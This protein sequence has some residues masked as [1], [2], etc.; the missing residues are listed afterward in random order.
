MHF[1]M[2]PVKTYIRRKLNERGYYWIRGLGEELCTIED[3]RQRANGIKQRFRQ[4]DEATVAALRKKY[5]QPIIGEVSVCRL[6]ELLAQVIDPANNYLYCGSQLT[7]TLQVAESME[8]AGINETTN[9]EMIVFGLIH[10]LGE[11]ALLKG[12]LPEHVEGGGK[13]PLRKYP[14]GIGLGNCAFTWDHSDIVHA[15]FRP[16]VSENIAWL[17]R[18]HSITP[19]CVLLMDERDRELYK[20]YHQTFIPHDRTYVFYHL[21]AKQLEDYRGLLEEAFPEKILF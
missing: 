13:R 20:S 18:Y 16:Y 5:E 3:F 12:E 8:R 7:H 17:L 2:R 9:R 21:P 10:D 14:A 1:L 4:Q 19:A 6:L 15:R 11:L